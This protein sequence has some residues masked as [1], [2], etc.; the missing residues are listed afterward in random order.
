MPSSSMI[1]SP[2]PSGRENAP[3]ASLSYPL[4]WEYPPDGSVSSVPR[5][6]TETP[7]TT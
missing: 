6:D 3:E 2:P 5:S 7:S 1:A 4:E